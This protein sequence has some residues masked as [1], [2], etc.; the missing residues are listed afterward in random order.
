MYSQV[1]LEK[2]FYFFQ[3][4][5]LTQESTC[6]KHI[7]IYMP[8]QQGHEKTLSKKRLPHSGNT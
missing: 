3:H 4:H 2:H 1:G 8:S 6:E 5:G 7:N